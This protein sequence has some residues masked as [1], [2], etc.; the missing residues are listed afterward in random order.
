VR[1][2]SEPGP[3]RQGVRLYV[4]TVDVALTG[5]LTPGI[6]SRPLNYASLPPAPAFS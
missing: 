1:T 5:G 2:G 3:V 4:S 6:A